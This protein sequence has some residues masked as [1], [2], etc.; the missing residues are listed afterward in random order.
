MY[1]LNSEYSHVT[2]MCLYL[3]QQLHIHLYSYIVLHLHTNAI[4]HLLYISAIMLNQSSI[5]MI[6]HVVHNK[7]Q[8]C[9][10]K[11]YS[12]IIIVI[13]QYMYFP[14][15]S[16]LSLVYIL[17]CTVALLAC[18]LP[19]TSLRYCVSSNS[20]SLNVLRGSRWGAWSP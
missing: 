14:V 17:T 1:P 10:H 19:T 8:K 15:Y 12:T 13:T 9:L 7:S 6:F 5:N 2:F 18:A 20:S 16:Y 11:K 4:S 3:M